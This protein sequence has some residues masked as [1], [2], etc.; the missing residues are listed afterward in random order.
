MVS[1]KEKKAQTCTLNLILI[2]NRFDSVA[3]LCLES[4]LNQSLSV[5][6]NYFLPI[7]SFMVLYVHRNRMVHQGRGKNGTG[8]E[9]HAWQFWSLP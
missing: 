7:S 3:A 5:H 9:A 4:A 8:N 2:F 6:F 1:E